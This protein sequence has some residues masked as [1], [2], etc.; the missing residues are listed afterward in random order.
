M[1]KKYSLMPNEAVILKE[2]GVE[3]G[4]GWMSGFTDEL[5]LTNQNIVCTSKGTFGNVKDI[6]R[7]PLNQIKKYEG[8]PQIIMGKTSGGMPTLE[9]YLVNG[10]VETFIFKN[11]N[12]KKIRQ[13]I[14]AVNKINSGEPVEQDFSSFDSDNE[15][16]NKIKEVGSQAMEAGSEILGALG[17]RPGKKAA[18][19]ASGKCVS[20]S[21]PIA[22]CKGQKVKCKY[23]DTEQI[24]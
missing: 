18:Q 23:C 24:L 13:W 10:A 7:Y 19:A 1:E 8:K 4:E 6:F 11:E 3:H 17:I 22:G 16:V 14:D 5:V 9:I 2:V 20:C 15:I 21:A 12:K